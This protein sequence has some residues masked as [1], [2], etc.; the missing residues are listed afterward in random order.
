[1]NSLIRK[2]C[3]LTAVAVLA[4]ASATFAQSTTVTFT[5]EVNT[6]NF[7][8]VYVD[9]YTANVGGQSV[10]VLCDDFADEITPNESWTAS[11]GSIGPGG[12]TGSPLFG[13][14]NLPSGETQT[15]LY[16]QVAYLATQLL[17]NVGN[18]TE[19]AG[20]SYA[21]WQ[22]TY[23]TGASPTASSLGS[24]ASIIANAVTT[25]G[26]LSN[27]PVCQVYYNALQ[28]LSTANLGS[29]YSFEILTPT[30]WP[31]GDG[32]PQEFLTVSTPEAS[33]IVMLGADLLGVLALA[34]FFR[35]RT[36]QP[37]S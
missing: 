37:I 9:P 15:Q 6:S 26:G 30:S 13:Y 18:A 36:L 1:M 5:G 12:L 21:I 31:S 8:G 20:L 27:C 19:Q 14:N 29:A 2:Y 17:Q 25:A 22:L 16:Q 35:R 11:I 33:T 23:E 10:V 4:C 28:G 32:R 3:F 7:G 24:P 34:F